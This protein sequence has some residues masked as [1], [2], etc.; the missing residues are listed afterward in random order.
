MTRQPGMDQQRRGRNILVLWGLV[1]LAVTYGSLL[2]YRP[3]LTGQSMLDGMVGVILG[4]YICSHPAANAVD[5]LF[6][7][8]GVLR[9]VSSEWSGIGWLAL[10]LLVMLIGWLVIVDGATRFVG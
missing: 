2:H 4:L 10:N 8:R 6:L 7:A 5:L 9:Q 1:L 3:T